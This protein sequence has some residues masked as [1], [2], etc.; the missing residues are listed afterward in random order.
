MRNCYRFGEFELQVLRVEIGE[1]E[2][3]LGC[4]A[5][6]IVRTAQSGNPPREELIV[7]FGG[8]RFVHNRFVTIDILELVDERTSEIRKIFR[9]HVKAIL[10]MAAA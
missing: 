7:D 6:M 8:K 1:V 10:P 5:K 9:K 3:R 2:R 4:T